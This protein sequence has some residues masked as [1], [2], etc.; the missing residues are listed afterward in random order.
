VLLEENIQNYNGDLIQY[1]GDGSLS[2]FNSGIEAVKCAIEIQKK[3]L[4]E[5]KIPIRIGLH[6]G[7]I[8]KDKDG[9]FGDG[10]NVASRIESLSV[11]GSVLIS[12]KIQSEC[13]NHPEIQTKNLGKYYLKNVKNH[14][15]VYAIDSKELKV[16]SPSELKLDKAKSIKSIAVLPFVNMSSDPENEYFSDGITEEI[17]NALVKLEEL[18][19]TSRTSSFSFKGKNID[20][21]EIGKQLNINNILEGSVRKAGNRIR[22]TAQLINTLDGYH[23]WSE[24]YDRDLNDIFK[25]QDE[26]SNKIANTLRAK[27]TVNEK[28]ERLVTQTT[29]NL[30]V[31]NLYLKGNFNINKWTPEAA[32]KGIELLSEAIEI[33]PSFAPAY[34]SLAFCYTMLGALGQIP[35]KNAYKKAEELALKAIELNGNLPESHTALGLVHIF[36]HWD[37]EAAYNSFQRALCLAPGDSKVYHAYFTY[38]TAVG[39]LDEALKI[40]KEAVQLDP[41]S[42]PINLALGETYI[43]MDLLEEAIEQINKT[44]ELDPNFRTA[45]EAKAWPYLLRGDYDEAITIFKEYQKKTGDELKGQGGLGYAYA[46]SGNIKK[47]KEC[48]EKI[49]KREERDKDVTLNMDYIVVYAGL[50]DFD[51]VFYYLGKAM[52]EGNIGYFLRTHPFAKE[53]RKDPRFTTFLK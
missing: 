6:I 53:I 38:L 50:K 29:K 33:E 19:V 28:R 14:I 30:D 47:A 42:L 20:A 49:R 36:S 35:V 34:S 40:L 7:D 45:I 31:Y 11:P 9:I 41:L 17:L 51:K 37:L 52:D 39:K 3:L 16:P 5:P 12:D 2:I 25:V 4:K 46:V 13:R 44:L 21:R 8:V 48:I 15:E 43:N 24:V 26:I 27:L 1:Y 10:V 32:K 22:I 23:I 18:H